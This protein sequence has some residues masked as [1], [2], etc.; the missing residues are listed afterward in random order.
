MPERY[1]TANLVISYCE[2]HSESVHFTS[3]YSQLPRFPTLRLTSPSLSQVVQ[4]LID[5]YTAATREDYKMYS[6][7][8]ADKIKAPGEG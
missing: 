7:V 1:E 5:E 8:P 2:T 4:Q 3:P 6:G